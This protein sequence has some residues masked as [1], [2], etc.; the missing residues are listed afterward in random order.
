MTELELRL[1]EL[2]RELAFPPAPDLAP[3]V[4]E[5]TMRRPFFWG[6]VAVAVAVAAALSAALAVPQARTAILRFFHLGGATVV[7][8][9]TLPRTTE[10]SRATGLGSP[11][12]LTQA[13]RRAGSRLELPPGQ[14]PARAFVLGDSLVTVVLRT[15]GKTVLLSEFP[16]LGPGSLRKLT[17]AEASVQ[18]VRVDGAEALWI[19]GPH[20][21][22]Y[23]GRNGFA[24]APVRVRGNVLLWTHGPLTLRLEGRLTMEQALA[25]ARR[26]R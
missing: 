9:E 18:P 26:T 19:E 23:F 2:G 14:R 11:V 17:A 12:T 7:R 1:E 25:L 6:R 10:R 4:L 20:A 24:Q 8:V 3:A 16:S 13:E 22:E 21:F 15:D 5:R